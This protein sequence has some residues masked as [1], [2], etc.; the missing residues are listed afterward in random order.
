MLV[1][2]TLGIGA[3][4]QVKISQNSAG[5]YSN[6]NLVWGMATMVGIYISGGIS[7]AHLNPVITAALAVFRGFPMRLVPR[8]ILAQVLGAFCGALII[9]GK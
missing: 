5:T 3:D 8:Y 4:C 6:M 9:Y 2:V 7:G 1:L